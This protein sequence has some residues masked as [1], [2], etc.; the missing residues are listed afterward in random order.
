MAEAH[1]VASDPQ[2][3]VEAARAFETESGTGPGVDLSSITDRMEIRKAVHA[4]DVDAAIERVNDMNPEL[5]EKQQPLFFHL[6]Q[7]RL[8]ELIRKGQ[9]LEALEFAQEYL[10]PQGEE[11]P[12]F[13]EELGGPAAA[14]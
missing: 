8:I 12:A 14:G 3:Y 10:A 2:G 5:L 4:G 1:H 9:T 7:Q 13:L 6:Q 11:H